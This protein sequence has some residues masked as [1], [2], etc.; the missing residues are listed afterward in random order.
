MV[1][2]PI[3]PMFLNVARETFEVI[4]KNLK[5]FEKSVDNGN[6]CGNI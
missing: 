4:D 3:K 2:I 5:Y 1:K 6:L